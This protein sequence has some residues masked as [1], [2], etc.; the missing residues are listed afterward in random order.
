MRLRCSLEDVESVTIVRRCGDYRCTRRAYDHPTT[1]ESRALPQ[2]AELCQF[3]NSHAPGCVG[4]KPSSLLS[5]HPSQRAHASHK[6]TP[7]IVS[8]LF[9]HYGRKIRHL[10]RGRHKKHSKKSDI[11]SSAETN[12]EFGATDQHEVAQG[13]PDTDAS[14]PQLVAEEDD[15]ALID[16]AYDEGVKVL[17]SFLN[18]ASKHTLEDLQ[19]F[20][21][22][23]IPA[24]T[25]VRRRVVQIPYDE[26][27]DKAEQLLE[28]Q[29]RSYGDF[30]V[31]AVGG[32]K[33]WKLR[34]RG[35]EGEWLE[36]SCRMFAQ[37]HI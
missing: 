1:V 18:F 33:W 37:I 15:P 29:L 31:K 6:T 8:T 14:G 17:K 16:F 3:V 10:T 26:C 13:L 2:R 25:W 11:A 9:T 7:T 23:R 20:T 32:M 24:P 4:G 5:P 12:T 36:V 34:G 22:L 28:K 21:A 27:I 35:L 30:G 19:A